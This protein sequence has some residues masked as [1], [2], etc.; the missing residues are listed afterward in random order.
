MMEVSYKGEE[1]KMALTPEQ[2]KRLEYL[3]SF[4]E[5]ADIWWT[6]SDDQA[7]IEYY[8]TEYYE[9]NFPNMT[10]EEVKKLEKERESLL[11]LKNRRD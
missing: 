10:K 7:M 2:E 9:E 4:F 1:I 8:R 3:N 11:F 5:E 6:F